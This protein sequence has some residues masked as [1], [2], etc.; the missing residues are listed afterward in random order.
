MFETEERGSKSDRT[1]ARISAAAIDSFTTRGYTDTTMRSI[2]E[3]AGVS[4]GN[5]YYYFPSKEHLVQALYEQVQREHEHLARER[6]EGVTALVDRLRTVYLSGLDALAPYRAVA[7]GFLTAMIPPDS[8]LNPLSTE[9]SPARDTTVALFRDAVEGAQHRL[10][11]DVV[12]PLPE[13]LLVGHLALVLRWTYDQSPDQTNTRTL[14][15][16]GLRLLALALPFV[17]VPGVHSA[18]RDL[19]VQ[20]A[21][22]RS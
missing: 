20:V 14:L 7:P 6:L 3:Q 17:R 22:V 4:V 9:S 11:D 19:L 16:T 18:V 1:R 13:A 21:E 2:A 15:A 10:P 8:P 12:A 5:A